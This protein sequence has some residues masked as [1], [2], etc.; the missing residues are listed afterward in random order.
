MS[1][2]LNE[3]SKLNVKYSSKRP[4][5]LCLLGIQEAIVPENGRYVKSEKI[6]KIT[7]GPGY[8]GTRHLDLPFKARWYICA[9]KERC[10]LPIG[11]SYIWVSYNSQN[12]QRSFP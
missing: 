9:I 1:F 8:I 10:I 12:K 3:V 5:S 4:I 6:I 2:L 11:C 7:S